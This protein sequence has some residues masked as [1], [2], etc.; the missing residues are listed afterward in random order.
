MLFRS[1]YLVC[2]LSYLSLQLVGQTFLSF[3]WDILL[4]EVGFLCIFTANA[5][6]ESTAPWLPRFLA[7]LADVII[8]GIVYLGLM[9]VLAEFGDVGV[10]L[11]LLVYF[12][13]EWFYPVLFELM[14]GG[15]T[16][17][18]RWLGLRVVNDDGTPVRLAGSVVRNLVR[19]VDF[20]P[21]LYAFG[22]ISMMYNRDFKRLG[23]LSAGTLVVYVEDSQRIADVDAASSMEPPWPLTPDEQMTL[24][25]FAERRSHFTDEWADALA[26][27]AGPLVEGSPAPADRLSAYARWIAGT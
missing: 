20:L 1:G 3:Q 10:G 25:D 16:P 21:A 14:M 7:W 26:S 5:P 4:L 19:F 17:G 8:R 2:W 27:T 11:S 9:M 23:D 22:L 18:K 6:I 13:L 12:V 15:A 24:V